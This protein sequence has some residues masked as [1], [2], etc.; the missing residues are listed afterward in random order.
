MS[1]TRKTGLKSIY[2]TEFLRSPAWFAR[3]DRWFRDEQATG[4]TL[5]CAACGLPATPRTLELHH[6][7]YAGVVLE[8]GFWKA[9][10]A[11]DD[12]VSMHPYCHDLLHRLID[13]DAVLARNRTRRAASA[14]ALV[15]L[16][17]SLQSIE[18]RAS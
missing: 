18:G 7:D 2:R 1:N 15:R 3:R 11:H 17:R 8:Q 4:H 16:R 6:L 13:R 5:C 10:E 9:L 14:H 12:L